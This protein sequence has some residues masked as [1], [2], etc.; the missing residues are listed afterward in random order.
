[1]KTV[2]YYHYSGVDVCKIDKKDV[3]RMLGT[4]VESSRELD[5]CVVATNKFYGIGQVDF[6]F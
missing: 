5:V 1:M 2:D 3:V 4:G 6:V